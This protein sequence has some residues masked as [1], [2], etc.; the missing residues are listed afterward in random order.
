MKSKE[1]LEYEKEI[2]ENQQELSIWYEKYAL[3]TTCKYQYSDGKGEPDSIRCSNPCREDGFYLDPP[4]TKC[5][6]ISYS[7]FCTKYPK[8]LPVKYKRVI[9]PIPE[10]CT[11]CKNKETCKNIIPGIEWCFNKIIE[12]KE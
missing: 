10:Y 12:D 7:D 6:I 11:N 3:M 1:W 9:N 4:C 5:H 8:P 2:K